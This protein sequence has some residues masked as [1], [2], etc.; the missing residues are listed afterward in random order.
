MSTGTVLD[1]IL[2]QLPTISHTQE[3]DGRTTH[4]CREQWEDLVFADLRKRYLPALRAWWP[5]HT[6]PT[7]TKNSIVIYETRCHENLEFLILNTCYFAQSWAL[8]IYCSAENE[9]FVY[10]IL[11][12]HKDNEGVHVQ[13]VRPTEGAYDDERNQYNAALTSVAFWDGLSHFQHA[14]LAEVDSYLTDHL[15]KIGNLDTFDYVASRWEWAPDE[16]GGGGLSIRR[17]STMRAIC[18]LGLKEP[19]QDCWASE[20]IKRLGGKVNNTLFAESAILQK[21]WGVHQWWSFILPFDPAFIP[22]YH[23]YLQLLI[24]YPQAPSL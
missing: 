16:P 24:E 2:D 14:L 9:A 3:N 21:V 6:F 1:V 5:T 10:G 18:E 17:V 11:G 20:G 22:I 8:T 23:G 13:V 12:P 19:M 7:V 15:E 4:R